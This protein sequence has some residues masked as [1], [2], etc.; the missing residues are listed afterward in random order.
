MYNKDR[1]TFLYDLEKYDTVVVITDSKYD[2]G[3]GY[4]E[5]LEAL[6]SKGNNNIYFVRWC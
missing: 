2:E 1:N 3:I 5:L 4:K 6:N